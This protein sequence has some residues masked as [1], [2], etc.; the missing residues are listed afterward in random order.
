MYEGVRE[1]GVMKWLVV[2]VVVRR[3]VPGLIANDIA[4]MWVIHESVLDHQMFAL[5]TAL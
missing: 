2:R 5:E 4:I 3:F 1:N